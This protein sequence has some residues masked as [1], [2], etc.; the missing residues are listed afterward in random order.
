MQLIPNL[1]HPVNGRFL[2][3]DHGLVGLCGLGLRRR[4]RRQADRTP[5]P[6]QRSLEAHSLGRSIRPS[7]LG[8]LIL[9]R[10][11]PRNKGR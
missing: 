10:Y 2:R 3:A 5:K 7:A 1:R 6:D 4:H 9:Q 11:L 8:L